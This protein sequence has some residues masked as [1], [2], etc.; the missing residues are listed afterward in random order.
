MKPII[1]V[2]FLCL[3]LSGC[4]PPDAGGTQDGTQN[5]EGVRVSL[6]LPDA[7]E[8]G[9]A[10]LRVYVLQGNGAVSD[11]QVTVTGNMTHAGMEPVIA[12]AT[13]S[14]PGLYLTQAFN[15][16][17]AGDWLLTADVTLPD[18]S[19]AS[20]DVPVTVPGS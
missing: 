10:E 16:D 19:R 7:P 9:P 20:D 13:E 12:E 18:G 4:R 15:F 6:E 8:V 11:A 3:L 17:M 14:E 1:S 2:L 5:P